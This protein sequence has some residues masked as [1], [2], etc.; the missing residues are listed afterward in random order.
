[1]CHHTVTTTSQLFSSLQQK[2]HKN[3]CVAVSLVGVF[4]F[5]LAVCG[6]FSKRKKKRFFAGIFSVSNERYQKTTEF[7]SI[8]STY[9]KCVTMLQSSKCLL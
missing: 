8:Y 6:D 4:Q 5:L 9:I 3:R 2:K 7:R 1:M